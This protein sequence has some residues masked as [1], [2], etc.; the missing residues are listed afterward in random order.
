MITREDYAW[1]R[2]GAAVL[3]KA[4]ED[5]RKLCKKKK[6]HMTMRGQYVSLTGI[7]RFLTTE[8]GK[9]LCITNGLDPLRMLKQL[10]AERKAAFEE[11]S[12]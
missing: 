6:K 10:Q 4:V 5:Y 7:E 1:N 2:L 11:D 8:Y 9:A 3:L 12:I